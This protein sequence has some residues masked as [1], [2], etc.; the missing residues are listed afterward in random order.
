MEEIAPILQL[1]VNEVCFIII[2]ISQFPI[3]PD[4]V[5]KNR[6]RLG[7][8]KGLIIILAGLDG[9]IGWALWWTCQVGPITASLMHSG[10]EGGSRG[11]PVEFH[12]VKFYP[13]FH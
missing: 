13:G 8:L 2:V 9:P 10:K 11:F 5:K 12:K 4:C 7:E 1:V 6:R 3:W